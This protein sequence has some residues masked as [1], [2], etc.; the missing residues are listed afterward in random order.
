MRKLCSF[1]VM[2]KFVS[3]SLSSVLSLFLAML[4]IPG[5]CPLGSGK[6]STSTGNLVITTVTVYESDGIYLFIYLFNSLKIECGS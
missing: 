6:I 1:H 3:A 4:W 2:L 5:T